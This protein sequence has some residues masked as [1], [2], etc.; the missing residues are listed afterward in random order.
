[1]CK[2]AHA[3]MHICTTIRKKRQN[4]IKHSYFQTGL[5]VPWGKFKHPEM[6]EGSML[7][8]KHCTLSS[9]HSLFIQIILEWGEYNWVTGNR[10]TFVNVPIYSIGEWQQPVWPQPVSLDL[11]MYRGA[12][13]VSATEGCKHCVLG[14]A[15]AITPPRSQEHTQW[16]THDWCFQS[17][18]I[19]KK[20]GDRDW[21]QS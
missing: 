14:A 13:L 20:A 10:C 15:C 1:M 17:W 7:I 4:G 9:G 21:L 18:Q 19:C 11:Y 2:C 5:C 3:P 16:Q 6:W 12:L 8:S